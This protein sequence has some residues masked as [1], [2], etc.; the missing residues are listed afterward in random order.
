MKT[1]SIDEVITQLTS[2]P[3]S[4]KEATGAACVCQPVNDVGEPCAG[5]PH[6]RFDVAAGG[7]PDQSATPHGSPG[8]LPPTLHS[9]AEPDLR[10]LPIV[11]GAIHPA[12]TGSGWRGQARVVPPSM[13][14]DYSAS[15]R[16]RVRLRRRDRFSYRDGSA[17][18]GSSRGSS[19]RRA[20]ART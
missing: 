2:I 6:A 20:T 15:R 16:Q 18:I 19:V 12:N 10:R 13:P 3:K 11:L 17:T 5:E 4:L 1:S 7:N 8:R 14:R 9:D